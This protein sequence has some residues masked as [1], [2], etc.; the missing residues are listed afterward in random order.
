MV[1]FLWFI[2][3]QLHSHK[4]YLFHKIYIHLPKPVIFVTHYYIIDHAIV[5]NTGVYSYCV[6]LVVANGRWTVDRRTYGTPGTDWSS[7]IRRN[8]QY[9]A[10][11]GFQCLD[12]ILGQ[13]LAFVEN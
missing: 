1:I 5:V 6:L 11:L 7:G 9:L 2:L 13:Y 12:C 10:I 4:Y 3:R 8:G